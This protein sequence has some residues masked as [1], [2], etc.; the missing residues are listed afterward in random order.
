MKLGAL[1]TVI[2]PEVSIARHLHRAAKSVTGKHLIV[3]SHAPPRGA[4]DLAIRFGTRHIGS[5]ALRNFL[6]KRRDVPLVICGHVHYCGARSDKLARST[7]VNAASH[8]DPGAPGR[9]A[10]IEL[11][12]GKVL[13]VEWTPRGSLARY[14]A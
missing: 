6:F 3:V 5:T 13:S 7:I 10:V 12:S 4:V 14:R 8:D 2:Y 1:G 9:V 11:Q